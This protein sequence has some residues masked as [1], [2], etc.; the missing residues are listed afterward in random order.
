[1]ARWLSP[2]GSVVVEIGSD[3][4]ETVTEIFQRSGGQQIAV[5]NDLNGLPRV[6]SAGLAA[7]QTDEL[8]LE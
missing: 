8:P 4:A 1:M 7:P 3:Q 6:I 2:S 5:V